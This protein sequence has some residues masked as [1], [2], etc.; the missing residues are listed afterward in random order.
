MKR[1]NF[2]VIGVPK[3]G[4]T[5]LCNYLSE[6][7]SI[8]FSEKKEPRFFSEDFPEKHRRIDNLK[9]YEKLFE[10]ADN[11]KMVG[12]GSGYYLFSETAVQ[13]IIGYNPKAKFIVIGREPLNVARSWHKH[14]VN[15]GYESVRDFQMA[16]D[17]D[18]NKSALSYKQIMNWEERVKIIQEIIPKGNLIVHNLDKKSMED[19]YK[20]SLTFLGLEYDNRTNFPIKNKGEDLSLLKYFHQNYRRVLRKYVLKR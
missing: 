16:L 14:L 5:S 19:I 12:E 6:H 8:Y 1:P 13:K 7:P 20:I 10:N 9:D 3:C 18:N 2:F 17:K 4:T 15:N 11:F